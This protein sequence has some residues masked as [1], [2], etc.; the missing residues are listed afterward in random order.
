MNDYTAASYLLIAWFVCYVLFSH[1]V[2]KIKDSNIPSLLLLIGSLAV[3][4]FVAGYRPVAQFGDTAKYLY[5]FN[6][7]TDILYAREDGQFYYGNNELLFWPVAAFIKWLGVNGRG[8]LIFIL[9]WFFAFGLLSY[10]K[11]VNSKYW[12]VVFCS[13][14]LS[15]HLVFV[16]SIRQAMVEPLILFAFYYCTIKRY[17]SSLFLIST[18]TLFH[19][20]AYFSFPLVFIRSRLIQFLNPMYVCLLIL[21]AF[22]I[23]PFLELIF[24]SF[25][26]FNFDETIDS[27]IDSYVTEGNVN[28]YENLWG[29]KQFQLMVFSSIAYVLVFSREK[30]RGNSLIY[31]WV[32]YYLLLVILTSKIPIISG[33]LM[34]FLSLVFPIIVWDFIN[35]LK[36]SMEQKVVI[37]TILFG[38]LGLLVINNLSAQIVLGL[39][40]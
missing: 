37:Y 5:S 35:I 33:R 12:V 30:F 2:Y 20:S 8:W 15:Y 40:K 27:K 26:M 18:G 1:S 14:F 6:M 4:I 21:I 34:Q 11:L 32:L 10:R 9:V 7:L 29:L 23:S 16:N 28:E 36:V 25:L 31:I 17:Y 39:T 19:Y 22:V 3:L 24:D 38:M 13:L